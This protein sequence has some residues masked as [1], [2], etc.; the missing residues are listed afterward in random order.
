MDSWSRP[1]KSQAT[2][3]PFYLLPGGASTPYCHSC[4]RVIGSRKKTASAAS[5]GMPARYCSSRCRARKPGKRDR[6]IEETFVR[7][8]SG[9]ETAPSVPA[10]EGTRQGSRPRKAKGDPRILVS[11]RTV[12]DAVF[13]HGRATAPPRS[14]SSSGGGDYTSVH[15]R[16]EAAEERDAPGTQDSMVNGDSLPADTLAGS[17][18]AQ[19]ED[20]DPG[21]HQ[22]P[23]EGGGVEEDVPDGAKNAVGDSAVTE[24]RRQGQLRAQEREM[25]RCAARRG[26]VF[27]FL[28]PVP[29]GSM[30][31]TNHGRQPDAA[32]GGERRLCEAVMAGKVVEPS[33]AKGDWGIRWRE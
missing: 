15:A 30:G 14:P 23:S 11:C 21:A 10:E 6:L 4:G 13:G 8:L 3:V 20:P 33:F 2:P 22:T 19:S 16:Q 26:V 12:E 17:A 31:R 32:E 27:G 5:A 24:K 28:M 18:S 29:E 7:F 9:A 1:S 25:V